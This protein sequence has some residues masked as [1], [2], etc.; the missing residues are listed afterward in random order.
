MERGCCSV[1]KGSL[2]AAGGLPTDLYK[3]SIQ[4]PY[5][6]FTSNHIMLL[7]SE[8]WHCLI[9]L[10]VLEVFW[11]YATL[12]IF[13][14]NNNNN[15]N[16]VATDK[17]P[18]QNGDKFRTQADSGGHTGSSVVRTR[19]RCS[20]GPVQLP[21]WLYKP[22]RPTLHQ[23]ERKDTKKA[24]NDVAETSR[25]SLISNDAIIDIKYGNVSLQITPLPPTHL[26]IS[27]P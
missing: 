4:M 5:L 10:G 19:T 20:A 9:L 11:F 22:M 16:N 1:R 17:V 18:A 26:T 25:D 7:M 14:D 15:N 23:I 21:L 2:E 3:Y 13:V 24:G 6:L 12:I 27:C 8:L